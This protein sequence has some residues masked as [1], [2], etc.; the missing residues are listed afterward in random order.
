MNSDIIKEKLI[1]KGAEASLFYGHWFGKE[2][3]FK[4][5]I[6]KEYRLEALD[7]KI[8]I[9][10]TLS[11]G[12][13][14]ILIKDY[15]VNVP[16]VYEI[17]IQNSTI[18]MKYIEGQKLKTILRDLSLEKKFNY[19]NRIGSYIAI[20]HKN[21]HIHGD[22][23]TSNLIVT[24]EEEIFLIDFGLHAYSDT[25]EDK[26]VDL[27]LFK[28]VLISSHGQDYEFCFKSFLEGYVSEYQMENIKM[29]QKIIKNINAIE[30]RGRYVKSEDRI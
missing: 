13:A 14:L 20:L 17:D 11:E 19:F 18:V 21:G 5:R 27:H 22:I 2:V 8:R 15:G 26:S 12:K 9:E 23:T 10:R 25:I 3:I 24:K 28:R 30:T 29:C 7:K 1:S 6:P 16:P 4:H